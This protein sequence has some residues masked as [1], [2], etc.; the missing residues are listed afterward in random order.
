[1]LL[2]LYVLF[3]QT[4]DDIFYLGLFY[5]WKGFEIMNIFFK[6]EDKLSE[7]AEREEITELEEADDVEIKEE[8]SEGFFEKLRKGLFGSSEKSVS[9]RVAAFL[10]AS[11]MLF[12]TGC[13]KKEDPD[14]N[15][16]NSEIEIEPGE[17]NGNNTT[18]EPVI[19]EVPS[20]LD[21]IADAFNL[22]NDVVGWL[23]IPGLDDVDSGVCRD[24]KKY[25]YNYKDITG[26][27][28]SEYWVTGAYYTHIRNTFGDSV[29]DLSTNT[30]IFGHSDLG[31]T[32]LLYMN[33]DPTGPRFSQLFSFK[34]PNFAEKT[35]YIFFSTADG[36][37]VWEVFSVFY[38]DSKLDGGQSLWY[39]EP[40]PGNDYETLLATVRSRSLYNYDVDVTADDKILTLSTCTVGYGLNVRKRYRFVVVAKLLDGEEEIYDRNAYFEINESA[41]IPSSY[42]KEFEEY[43]KNWEPGVSEKE[44]PANETAADTSGI[45]VTPAENSGVTVTPVE[46]S[47]V[48]VTPAENSDVTVTPAA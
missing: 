15:K 19:L 44:E 3:L 16:N 28:V 5:P 17:N 13:N 37:H 38:N 4:F 20:R 22:N 35:P 1:M 45:T 18:N 10:L 43:I 11:L 46:N 33:D 36:D 7:E 12:T 41:P 23:Y 42:S 48:T 8:K 21:K 6:N 31:K 14:E 24:K 34:D 27:Q 26:K 47:G 39:I 2:Y 29:D 40:E 9:T 30:V 32:H 25:S